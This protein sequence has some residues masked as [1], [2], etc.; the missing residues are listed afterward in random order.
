[1]FWPVAVVAAALVGMGKGGLPVVGMLGVP[2]LSLVISPIAAAGLLLPV[3]VVSDMFGLF[4]YRKEFNRKVVAIICIAATFGVGIG[5]AT[6]KLVPENLVTLLVGLIGASFALS[7]LRPRSGP[8]VARPIRVAPGLFW[9]AVAGF[10]SF[11]SHTGGLPY[12]VYVLPLRL[13]KAV[14]AATGTVA[15]AYINAIKLVPYWAL[16]QLSIGNL[17][18]AAVLAVPA[19]IAVFGGVR[20]VRI[21]P[22]KLFFAV[23]T[24]ALLLISL[25]LIWD[26]IA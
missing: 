17:E 6:A 8:V 12:Q 10:T 1:M 7:L 24:W 15:F 5:W 26:G 13:P 21:I 2:V 25:K 14:F 19:T 20:L 16:G 18:R 4:A 22:E 3:Y 23:V 11:V 9:G